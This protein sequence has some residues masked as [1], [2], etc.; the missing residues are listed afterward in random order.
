MQKNTYG[1]MLCF[2]FSSLS[3]CLSK[4]FSLALSSSFSLI[5]FCAGLFGDEWLLRLLL[6]ESFSPLS[7]ASFSVLYSAEPFSAASLFESLSWFE[8]QLE[9]RFSIEFFFFYSWSRIFCSSNLVFLRP[10]LKMNNWKKI[11]FY[12]SFIIVGIFFV[13]WFRETNF[14]CLLLVARMMMIDDCLHL[15]T[16]QMTSISQLNRLKCESFN[17]SFILSCNKGI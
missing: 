17:L 3:D 14:G 13:A 9:K 11:V 4:S 5:S 7:A 10:F 8:K 6:S 2:G 12:L 15:K 16:I 1:F